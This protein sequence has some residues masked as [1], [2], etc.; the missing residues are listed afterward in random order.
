MTTTPSTSGAGPAP[1][2]LQKKERGSVLWLGI[3]RRLSLLFGRRLS[4]VVVYGIAWYFLL[5]A[6][7]VR[8][9]SRAY[10]ERVLRR[11]AGWRDLY[12]HILTFSTTIH[13]R[14]Y[15]LNNRY[16]LFDIR[17]FDAERVHALHASGSGCFLFGA[18]LGSFE[19]LRSV[20]R[21]N[22]N[23][24][25][26]VAMNPENARQINASLAAINP[27]VMLDII[28][29]GP[30]DA[31]LEIHHRLQGGA[32]V[33]LL[34]D[35]ASGPDRYLELPFFG[36]AAP[37]PTGP[38]R[39]AVMLRHPVYFMAGLYRGGNR[40]D[41]HFEL[42]TDFTGPP[43]ANRQDEVCELLTKYVAALERYCYAEPFNWF[44]FYDFWKPADR[45]TT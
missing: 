13:D 44:N 28:T 31:M 33:G 40:Y 12:R 8:Q 16:D 41:V 38:F 39:T 21:D 20:A 29:L 26:C 3:M 42:L 36:S 7:S 27:D 23:L 34:A 6:K 22:P 43:M 1:E 18:H 25:V 35:R 10:L 11:P 5:S 24:R 4:R 45:E 32:M 17:I 2:W 37:F 30:L 14:L 15:L 19:M 9:A